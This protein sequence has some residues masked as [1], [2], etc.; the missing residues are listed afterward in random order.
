LKINLQKIASRPA[1]ARLGA[2]LIC[3]LSFWTPIAAPIYLWVSDRNLVTI[4]TMGLLFVLFLVLLQF[5]GKKVYRSPR[6]LDSYGLVT[7]KQNGL[8]LLVGVAIGVSFTLSLF[9]VFGL[10]GWV[11][12]QQPND[13]FPRIIREG[14][15]SGLGIGFAEE[16]VFRGWLLD[17]LQRDYRPRIVVW[18]DAIIFAMLHFIRPWSEILRS[19]PTFPAL[20]LFGLTMVWAKQGS[21]GRLG[22]PM[23][24]HAGLFWGYYI[25]NLGQ[26]VQYSGKVS[27]WITGVDRNPIAGLM[28]ILFLGVLAFWMRW[29]TVQG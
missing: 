22:L 15:I 11:I 4:L 12:W 16:L 8:E 6:L 18:V 23:G 14:I 10:L 2:F 26:L 20:V 25:V 17:E 24:L 3:L 21:Q 7:S 9:A 13:S 5:W 29:R 27:D 1:P 19:L 28:G